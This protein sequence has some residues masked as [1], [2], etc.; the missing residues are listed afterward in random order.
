MFVEYYF[1]PSKTGTFGPS[2]CNNKTSFNL[3][4]LDPVNQELH[5]RWTEVKASKTWSV[6]REGDLWKHEWIK[7]GTCAISSPS[8]NSEI[9]Y[10]KKGLEWSNK[11]QLSDILSKEGIIPNGSYSVT[12]FWNTLTNQLGK[13]PRIDCHK[14]KVR[15]CVHWYL[16][17]Y[18]IGGKSK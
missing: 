5:N 12:R 6:K 17:K 8:L 2:F 1:R 4:E 9:K 18:S 13:K 14:D 7:H 11:Y 10:F 15:N 16:F 3:H